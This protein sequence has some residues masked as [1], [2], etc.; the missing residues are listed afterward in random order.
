ML[1]EHEPTGDC[2]YSFFKFSQPFVS[3]SVTAPFNNMQT[4]KFKA[5][6]QMRF[7][8]QSVE[9]LAAPPS[10]D[11]CRVLGNQ[12]KSLST[13]QITQLEAGRSCPTFD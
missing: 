6:G 2:F 5:Q 3:V 12:I 7:S 10:F 1:W 13:V 8:L 11:N 9:C 4:L